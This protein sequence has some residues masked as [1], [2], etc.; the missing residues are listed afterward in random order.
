MALLPLLVLAFAAGI[1]LA[2]K[3]SFSYRGL[4]LL[5]LAALAAGII[6]PNKKKHA[7]AVLLLLFLGQGMLAYQLAERALKQPLAPL[8]NVEAE[9]LG[10][11]QDVLSS[12]AEKIQFDFYLEEAVLSGQQRLPVGA[13]IRVSVYRSSFRP[14]YGQPLKLHGVIKAAP[15]QRNP[16]GFNYAD[17][18][19]TKNVS[20]VMTAAPR[21]ITVLTGNKGKP[22]MTFF[23]RVRAKALALLQRFLPPEEAQLA[24]GFIFGQTE[25]ITEE[26][27]TAYQRL[28]LA[29][30][31]AVSGLHVGFVTSLILFLFMRL[32]RP[33]LSYSAAALFIL[34]YVFLTGGQ[35]PVWRAALTALITLA[36]KQYGRESE[37]LQTLSLAA[38]LLLYFRPLWLFSLSFQLSFAAAA[39]ILLLAPRLQASLKW[40]PQ[41]LA[42]PLSVSMAALL[43]V[44][45]LQAA[46]FGYFS[47]YTIPLNLLCVPVVGL[48]VMLGLLGILV[49][50]VSA[51][52]AAPIITMTL[53][54]LL[55]LTRLPPFCLRLPAA[56]LYLSAV[57]PLWWLLYGMVL[58]L[59]LLTKDK[60]RLQTGKKLLLLLLLGC[61][62]YAASLP[63][64]FPRQL[65]VTFL[66]VG[67]G[68]AVHIS[69]PAG[70]HLL[71]D[72]GGGN[73]AAGE[74]VV[75]PYLRAKGVSSLAA[76]ILTHPHDDHYGGLPAVL[77][78]LPVQLFLSNGEEDNAAAFS[79]L[80]AILEERDIACSSVST[81]YRLIIDNVEIKVLSPPA[82]RFSVTADDVNN[83]SL[84][85]SLS[86]GDFSLLLTGDA[87]SA[88]LN[89]L[90]KKYQGR[91]RADVLQVPHHGSR[92]A[93]S[94]ALLR[95]AAARAAVISVGS[96][97]F[98]H[99]HAETLRLL[100]ENKLAVY[101]TDLHGAITI[102]SD[103]KKWT[104]AAYTAP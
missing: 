80:L 85:L 78:A 41:F 81:G 71:V 48:V 19:E 10:Y 96:N 79:D 72:A 67:Q 4:L 27:L 47:F 42:S 58:L 6:I 3:F 5:L 49:G 88:A 99:P 60:V 92:N 70:Q 56:A 87:E 76:V 16:G 22:L 31:L 2:D 29:H 38:L 17:Y 40:C 9:Y 103:G 66:D 91:L 24:A 84:V 82:Q 69:T 45:P 53:P 61:L 77:S 1:A 101:R 86:Y 46:H 63:C 97:P 33:L 14:F 100:A 20:G 26:L 102:V 74:Q 35:P 50:L 104:I 89:E 11:V 21:Q 13:L 95:A 23:A 15:G 12:N 43:G 65:T 51:V 30:L 39:G 8:W 64:T 36:A 52:L 94:A 7:A 55:L 57:H 37:G 73:F 34:V 83:S 54:L 44:L 90:I 32:G 98:G 59:L 93:L 62:L 75:L 28:G 18:L 25:N 68:L